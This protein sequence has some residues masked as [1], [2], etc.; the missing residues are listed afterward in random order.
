MRVAHSWW[1]PCPSKKKHKI[2][3]SLHYVEI[4]QE[5]SFLQTRKKSLTMNWICQHLGIPRLQKLRNKCC[6]G[7]FYGSLSKLR[8]INIIGDQGNAI[9]TIMKDHF[10]PIWLANS[11]NSQTIPSVGEDMDPQKLSKIVTEATTLEKQLEIISWSWIFTVMLL[12]GI[13]T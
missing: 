12:L 1:D 7:V 11:N 8:Q 9:K 4:Q 13:Y 3:L 10:I 2:P 6:Y 5:C